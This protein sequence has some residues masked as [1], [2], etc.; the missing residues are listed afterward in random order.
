MFEIPREKT[1]N[2]WTVPLA[3]VSEGLLIGV[4]LLI[5]VAHVQMAPALVSKMVMFTPPAPPPPPPPAVSRP[6]PLKSVVKRFDPTRL[7][8]PVKFRQWSK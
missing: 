7:T 3:T 5:P 1:R 8:A 4:V 2:W 6:V